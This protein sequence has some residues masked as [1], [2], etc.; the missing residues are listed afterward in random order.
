MRTCL[1]A[2]ISTWNAGTTTK[3]SEVRQ[4]I[5]LL[6]KKFEGKIESIESIQKVDLD[7][8]NHLSGKLEYY[9]KLNFRLMSDLIQVR[10]ALK[11]RIEKNKAKEE[12]L[13]LIEHL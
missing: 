6:E 4:L 13:A 10:N 8:I 9:L 1:S 7:Q 5:D 2:P 11:P 3:K 12:V